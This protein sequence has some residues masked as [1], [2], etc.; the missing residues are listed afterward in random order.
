MGQ[1]PN[2]QCWSTTP[3]LC[4]YGVG[5]QHTNIQ[6]FVNRGVDQHPVFFSRGVGQQHT[7]IQCLSTGVLVNNTPTSSV[8]QQGCWSTTH[9]HPVF[10]NRGVGQQHT[11]IQCLATGVF[12]NN[13]PTSSVWQQ[14]YLSITHQ[15][16][17][18]LNRGVGQPQHPHPVWDN[19]P[20][21]SVC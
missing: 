18:F 1:H 20:A 9:Q 15:H 13:T 19:I 8:C 7:N 5:Q 11:N 16:P 6:Y 14:A 3:S 12:V 2:T 10:G 17:V 21:P 4:Q